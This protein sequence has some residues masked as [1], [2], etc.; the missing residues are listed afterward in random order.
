MNAAFRPDADRPA[1]DN[2]V[3]ARSQMRASPSKPPARHGPYLLDNH[4]RGAT[5]TSAAPRARSWGTPG[6]RPYGADAAPGSLTPQ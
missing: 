2:C 1:Q 4:K 5:T 6:L 3:P